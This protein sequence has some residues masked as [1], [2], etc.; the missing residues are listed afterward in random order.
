MK[1]KYVEKNGIER[2]CSDYYYSGR[3]GCMCRLKEWKRRLKTC[4]YDKTIH[5]IPR[6]IRKAIKNKSQKILVV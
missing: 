1:C 4:P 2:K 5:S 6:S 3:S